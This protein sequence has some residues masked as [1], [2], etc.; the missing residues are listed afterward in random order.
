[1]IKELLDIRESVL[2]YVSPITL[3]K[4][5]TGDYRIYV[6]C[7]KLIAITMK[8]KYLLPLID[9]QINKLGSHKYFTGLDL[10]SGYYQ[11]TVTQRLH[12]KDGVRNAKGAL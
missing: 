12:Y 7:R 5:K 10:A 3:V 1:M 6:D 9:D 4:K 2:P 11:V 8:D